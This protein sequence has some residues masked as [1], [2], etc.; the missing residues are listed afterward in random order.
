MHPCIYFEYLPSTS[1]PCNRNIYAF[2]PL[3]LSP[4]QDFQRSRSA[5]SLESQDRPSG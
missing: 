2:A 5:R 4:V 1:F 3:S